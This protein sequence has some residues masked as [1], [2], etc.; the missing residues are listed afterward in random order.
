MQYTTSLPSLPTIA[1]APA[2]ADAAVLTWPRA[3]PY[4]Q[5]VQIQGPSKRSNM[6][7]VELKQIRAELM[8]AHQS[9]QRAHGQELAWQRREDEW[10]HEMRNK[11]QRETLLVAKLER[12]KA[13]RMK[14]KALEEEL[15]A[16][17][18]ELAVTK[19]RLVA[20]RRS[21]AE[22]AELD[23]ETAKQQQLERAQ[24]R[25]R[26]V[27]LLV[28]MAVL[29]LRKAGLARGWST[30]FTAFD[31]AKRRRRWGRVVAARLMRPKLFASFREWR[32]EWQA[33]GT[34]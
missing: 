28:Q 20:E 22:G 13:K 12:E 3:A 4:S 11:S 33:R 26:Q 2:A 17:K 25:E 19:Q 18:E 31:T 30:W 24:E 32:L 1:A 5:R 14:R 23:E 27:Q 8:E 34:Q 21:K 29:R 16:V 15:A 7:E 10:K 6:L 9:M